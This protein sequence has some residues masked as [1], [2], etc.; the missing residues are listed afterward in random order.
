M[1]LFANFYDYK[2]IL[3][4]NKGLFSKYLDVK[5]WCSKLNE[6]EPIRNTIAHNRDLDNA[7]KK[8]EEAYLE[9]KKIVDKTKNQ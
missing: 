3:Q 2:E 8:I 7:F 4:Q 9:L 1:I 6:L 5:K